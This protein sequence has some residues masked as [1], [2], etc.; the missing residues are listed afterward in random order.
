MSLPWCMTVYRCVKCV[1]KLT[2]CTMPLS[3]FMCPLDAVRPVPSRI[4]R[5]AVTVAMVEEAREISR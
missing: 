2:Q 5:V 4:E 1:R 3:G